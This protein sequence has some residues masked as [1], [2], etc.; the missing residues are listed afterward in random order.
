MTKKSKTP[1]THDSIVFASPVRDARGRMVTELYEHEA[2]WRLTARPL[3]VPTGEPEASPLA[4]PAEHQRPKLAPIFVPYYEIVQ[5]L[6]DGRAV[7]F[8]VP[9]ERVHAERA[10]RLVAEAKDATGKVVERRLITHAE[11]KARAEAAEK[12]AAEAAKVVGP[13]G[14]G[15]EL[16]GPADGGGAA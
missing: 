15:C 8:L 12:R 6:P 10:P 1:D 14:A 11:A 4:L 2:T 9:V 3:L 16:V 13:V 7:A 5:E